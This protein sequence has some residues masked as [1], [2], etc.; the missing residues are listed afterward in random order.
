MIY[1]LLRSVLR[2]TLISRH[3]IVPRTSIVASA[4]IA[5][6]IRIIPPLLVALSL[7]GLALA[8]SQPQ[9][10]PP[11]Q[12]K[13][14]QTQSS[15]VAASPTAEANK[16]NSAAGKVYRNRDVKALL[17][18]DVSVVGPAAPPPG[19]ASGKGNIPAR[20]ASPNQA[21]QD[22]KAAAYWKARFT[23][24]R[25]KLAQDQK[26]LP[27]LQRQLEAER[28]QQDFVDPDTGQVYSDEFMNLLHQID[29]AKVAIQKDKQALSDLYDQFRRAGGL[30]GWIR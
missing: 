19:S 27:S 16:G 26:V 8:Q 21:D 11:P 29:A 20:T 6:R 18:D 22:T 14:K 9:T 12:P 10:P 13:S 24:A 3:R 28:V 4:A 30:P 2:E 15:P 5:G 17:S 25:N 7:T 23:S 1:N